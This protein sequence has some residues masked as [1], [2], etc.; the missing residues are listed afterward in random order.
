MKAKWRFRII[1]MEEKVGGKYSE[2][3]AWWRRFGTTV[4]DMAAEKMWDGNR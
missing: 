2:G 4:M 1:G 3:Q